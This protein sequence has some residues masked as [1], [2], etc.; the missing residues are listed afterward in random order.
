LSDAR[1]A[2]RSEGIRPAIWQTSS[3]LRADLG[4]WYRQ[5]RQRRRQANTIIGWIRGIWP[6]VQ[7]AHAE[8]MRIQYGGSVKPDNMAEFMG[9][10][11]IDGALVGGASLKEDSFIALVR[12]AIEAKG[13]S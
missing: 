7:D 6:T 13:L 4:N 8:A 10:P 1:F 9:Q 11:H 3:S 5:R 2:L 12:I